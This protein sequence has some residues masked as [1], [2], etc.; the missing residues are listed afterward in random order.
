[1]DLSPLFISIEPIVKAAAPVLLIV[2][3]LMIAFAVDIRLKASSPPLGLT[4]LFFFGGWALFLEQIATGWVDLGIEAAITIGLMVYLWVVLGTSNPIRIV[5]TAHGFGAVNVIHEW[6]KEHPNDQ[7][8]V[9]IE[10]LK[11]RLAKAKEA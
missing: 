6:E 2:A 10:E 8:T 4:Y 1:M 11:A 3:A 5:K 7:T 9:Q